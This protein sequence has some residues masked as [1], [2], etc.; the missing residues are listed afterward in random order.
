[1]LVMWRFVQSLQQ[2]ISR[3]WKTNSGLTLIFG[4]LF[5][6]GWISHALY[7]EYKSEDR[8]FSSVRV[9]SPSLKYINPLLFV[10]NSKEEFPEYNPLEKDIKDYIEKATKEDRAKNISVYFR[11]INTSGWLGVNKDDLYAPSS[12]LKVVV[13]L[14]YLKL[15]EK[16]PDIITKPIYY[17]FKDL[18][19]NQMIMKII[20]VILL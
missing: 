3:Q 11:D 4:T 9:D 10:D 20:I 7:I 1:M 13:L 5:L 18:I 8:P 2:F 12:M 15:A 6:F 14:A 16:D 19:K 17:N